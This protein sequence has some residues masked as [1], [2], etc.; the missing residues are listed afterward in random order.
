MKSLIPLTALAALVASGSLFAQTPAFSKPSGYVTNVIVGKANPAASDVFNLIGIPLQGQ[1]LTSGT[2]TALSSNSLTDSQANFS[3][4]AAGTYLLEITSGSGAGTIQDFNSFSATVLN[5]VSNL[6]GNNVAV[7][8]KYRVRQMQ[9]LSGIFGSASTS[10]L[11]KGTPTTADI[12]W[13]SDGVGGFDRFY[14]SE[15]APPFVPNPAWNKVGGGAN[16]ASTP[17]A[18]T[19]AILVQRRG[20]GD[21][22][23]VVT[24]EVK[25]D[26]VVYPVL[27]GTGA[28]KFNYYSTPF[29]TSLGSG[30]TVANSETTVESMGLMTLL[31][32]GSPTTA[33]ILWLPQGNGSYKRYYKSSAAPPFKPNATFDEIGGATG[34]NPANV[35]MPSAYIIQRR[36]TDANAV[37]SPPSGLSS[38]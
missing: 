31:K 6:A 29:P 25:T 21:V 38:L 14:I 1:A 19:D 32:E 15:P 33:D 24:G 16:P 28:G 12:V 7:G 37:A 5:L 20:V 4:L 18:Y 34:I 23:F 26:L 36:G 35:R 13:V 3:T 11:K 10:A 17:I 8:D 2:I 27:G 30:S 9:T 22:S